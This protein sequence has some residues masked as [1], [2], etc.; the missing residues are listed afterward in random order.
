MERT[1]IATT[2]VDKCSLAKFYSDKVQSLRLPT[3]QR[4]FVWDA[5]DV[6]KLLD[7]IV[8]GYPIGSIILWKPD[9]EFPSVPLIGDD[10][11]SSAPIYILDGQQRLTSLL[12]IMNGWKLKRKGKEI[13][14]SKICFIPESERF[15]IGEKKGIDVSLATRAAMADPEALSVLQ[16]NYPGNFH[17]VIK[18]VGQKVATYELPLYILESQVTEANKE[19]IYE[20]IAEIFTRVN[21]A[22]EPIGNLAMFLSF[23]AAIFPREAK[24]K[25]IELHEQFSELFGLDLEPVI[26]FVFSKLGMKQNQI[27]KVKAFKPAIKELK[28]KYDKK[29]RQVLNIIERARMSVETILKMLEIEFGIS[30]SHLLPSQIA[31]IPLFEYAYH[32][33]V[34]NV[35]NF[36]IFEK[37]RMLKWFLIASFNG[38]YSSS[39]NKRLE[40]DLLTIQ[41]KSRFPIDR[42]LRLMKERIRTDS[43]GREDIFSYSNIL[44]GR[45][46]KEYLMVL[47]ILLH[48]K[49]ATDWAGK[50]VKSEDA[51]IHHLFPRECLKE[52]GIQDEKLINCLAN[53]TLIN[54]DINSEIGDQMPAKYLPEYVKD[55]SVLAEHFIPINKKLWNIENYED[56]LGARFKLI[57]RALMELLEELS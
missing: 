8:H 48:R 39:P 56:F 30:S 14:T 18:L 20:G 52:E 53:L 57:W 51:A 26:R 50:R 55:E 15:Y 10:N 5:E 47:D 34:K 45:V 19:E 12:L 17:K 25:I 16:K 11:K 36:S 49:N 38:M 35:D 44:R 23:I 24:D 4:E 13:R 28:N 2:T 33:E 32:R 9:V 29:Q 40:E 54:P 42:L 7:S 37:R 31:L 21:S 22:G 41:A 46:G 3:I 1:K 27:T 6:K 43:I